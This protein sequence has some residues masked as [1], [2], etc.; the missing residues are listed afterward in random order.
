MIPQ[1][2]LPSN[3]QLKAH[4]MCLFPGTLCINTSAYQKS[5][6]CP[7]C[8]KDSNRIHRRYQRTL[9]D[10]PVSGHMAKVKLKARKYF[11]DN[12]GCPRK[13]FTERFEYESSLTVEE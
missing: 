1:F 9:V 2:I 3:L 8:G 11:C 10:L 12:S 13:V 4:T 7:V 5:S 6:V